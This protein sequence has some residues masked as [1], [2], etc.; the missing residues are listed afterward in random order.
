MKIDEQH[1]HQCEVRALLR[2]RNREGRERV[3]EFID[4]LVKTRGAEQAD[5]IRADCAAQWAAGNRGE[6]GDWRTER[7]E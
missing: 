5:A 2:L 1:R 4:S 3:H 7:K 6:F